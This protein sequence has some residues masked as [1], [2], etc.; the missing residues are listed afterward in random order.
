LLKRLQFGGVLFY[1]FAT[2][3]K[4]VLATAAPL[5]HAM[6]TDGQIRAELPSSFMS[7]KR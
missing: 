7:L 3:Y 1:D 4:S 5:I 2:K 6:A